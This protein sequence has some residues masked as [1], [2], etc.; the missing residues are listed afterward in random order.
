VRNV[1]SS[2]ASATI[3]RMISVLEARSSPLCSLACSRDVLSSTVPTAIIRMISVHAA[4][5]YYVHE[6]AQWGVL[7][8]TASAMIIRMKSAHCGQKFATMFTSLLK[9]AC[10]RVCVLSSPAPARIIR[11]ISVHGARSSLLC[12]LGCSRD[13]FSNLRRQ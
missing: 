9:R 7:S 13:V 2:P 5:R 6:L 10:S 4:S 3:I 1:R 8:P 11:M 12:S